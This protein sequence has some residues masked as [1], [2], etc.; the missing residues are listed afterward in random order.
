MKFQAKVAVSNPKQSQTVN[1]KVI[2][3]LEKALN[4]VKTHSP[5]MASEL[6]ALLAESKGV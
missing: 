5:E 2:R 3:I 6:D 4:L 1:D